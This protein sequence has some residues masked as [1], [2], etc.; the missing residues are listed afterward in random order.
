MDLSENGCVSRH[1]PLTLLR[2][3]PHAL[4]I[5][6]RIKLLSSC[7]NLKIVHASSEQKKTNPV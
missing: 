3:I 1:T 4:E 5:D 6:G 2:D 7:Y